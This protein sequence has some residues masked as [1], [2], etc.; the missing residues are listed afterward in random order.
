MSELRRETE[1]LVEQS[2][3]AAAQMAARRR[4]EA[5]VSLP[6]APHR[7]TPDYSAAT[8]L[9]G[10]LGAAVQQRQDT[11]GS[12]ILNEPHPFF[13]IPPPMSPTSTVAPSHV[14]R[15]PSIRESPAAASTPIAQQRTAIWQS[16][17][18]SP[19]TMRSAE[20]TP[21]STPLSYLSPLSSPVLRATPNAQPLGFIMPAP[22]ST[23]PPS[24]ISQAPLHSPALTLSIDLGILYT[25]SVPSASI[26]TVLSSVSMLPMTPS[27]VPQASIHTPIPLPH[28]PSPRASPLPSPPQSRLSP[29]NIPLPPSRDPSSPSSDHSR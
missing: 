10:M 29:P 4:R 28:F 13:P 8:P 6:T 19:R 7:M 15:L 9:R 24:P 26:H 17:V 22:L 23:V 21:Q 25:P 14:S 3:A 2:A 18:E 12:P 11:Q 1:D 20:P 5:R 16:A 27:T